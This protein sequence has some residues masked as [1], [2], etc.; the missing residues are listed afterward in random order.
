MP[1]PLS[2]KCIVHLYVSTVYDLIDVKVWLLEAFSAWEIQWVV[3]E[4]KHSFIH[5]CACL[6]LCVYLYETYLYVCVLFFILV[7]PPQ[8]P[9]CVCVTYLCV[10]V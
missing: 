6:G 8:L 10:C 4:N 1:L 3:A 7:C 2:I 9:V 5:S